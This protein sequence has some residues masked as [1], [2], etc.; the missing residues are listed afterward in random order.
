MTKQE[1]TIKRSILYMPGSN[2]R[3]LLKAQT[4]KADAFI[5]DLEDAVAMDAKEDARKQVCE[6]LNNQ[7]FNDKQIIIRINGL[8]TKWAQDDLKAVSAACPEAV[9]LPKVETGAAI[10]TVEKL[11]NKFNAPKSIKIWAM[12]ETPLGVLNAL[13]IAKSSPR[14]ECLVMGTSDL[15]ND[16]RASHSEKRTALLYSL[17]HTILAARAAQIDIIDGVH[18]NIEDVPGFLVACHQGKE[19]GF[20]GKS[21]I[22]PSQIAVANEVFGPSQKEIDQCKKIILVYENALKE[23][24]AVVLLEGVLI[25]SLHVKNA[26]RILDM[27]ELIKG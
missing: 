9:L 16:L 6:T 20:D 7:E 19:L 3:V 24:N 5:F 14:L 1:N 17:S 13:E 22:H 18:L 10:K 27:A 26:K 23:G 12:I 4:L 2:Q 15:L 8:E 21:L 11:L 25:E